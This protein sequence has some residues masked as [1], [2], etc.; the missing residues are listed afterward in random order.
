MNSASCGILEFS[1][2]VPIIFGAL[3]SIPIN[4]S[5]M[6]ENLNISTSVIPTFQRSVSYSTAAILRRHIA[7][8]LYVATISELRTLLV[9]KPI[10]VGMAHN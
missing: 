10:K 3:R 7:K 6:L 1:Y 5:S 9:A 8:H 4:L 2:I